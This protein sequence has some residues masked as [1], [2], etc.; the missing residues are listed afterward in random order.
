MCCRKDFLE[1]LQDRA[2]STHII[3][4]NHDEYFKN[5]HV[6]NALDEIVAGR[7]SMIKTYTNPKL[8][9]IEGCLIQ[10]LP[11]ITESNYEKSIES[12]KTF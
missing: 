6:V 3:A 9:D 11:W 12:I 8:I 4:G 7:Y 5:T 1:P 10:L 2:I